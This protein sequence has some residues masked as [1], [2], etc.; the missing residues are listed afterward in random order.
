MT[1]IKKI[2]PYCHTSYEK[3][4]LAIPG[5]YWGCCYDA[6]HEHI[7]ETPRAPQTIYHYTLLDSFRKIVE[8]SSF[9]ASHYSQMNDW[10]EIEIGIECLKEQFNAFGEFENKAIILNQIENIY[11]QRQR[12]F[13]SSFSKNV[14][15]LSQWRAYTNEDAG[16]VCIGFQAEKITNLEKFVLMPCSYTNEERKIDLK[17]IC[18]MTK[19]QVSP[20]G[21]AAIKKQK[22]EDDKMM[23]WF[24]GRLSVEYTLG[25]LVGAATTI[26][27]YG[28]YEEQEWRLI[29]LNPDGQKYP[30]KLSET[31]RRYIEFPFSPKDWISEIVISPHG[32]KN[33]IRNVIEHYKTIGILSDTCKIRDS[34]IPFR[35]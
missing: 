3:N 23:S 22:E 10:K 26:K 28:F 9:R 31:N 20:E 5:V 7:A 29:A 13:L 1:E 16:G 14:D 19:Y 21:K 35:G 18:E 4:D 27:D 8:S 11:T 15:S 32:N 12:C 6:S 34:K 25:D 24:G 2:C 30:E 17:N 33:E